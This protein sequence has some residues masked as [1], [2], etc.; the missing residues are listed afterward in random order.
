MGAYCANALL[1]APSPGLRS[2]DLFGPQLY[3]ALDI[4]KAAEE[5][6]GKQA[7]LKL[8]KPE[9]LNDYFA[10]HMPKNCADEMAEMIMA[11][12]PGGVLTQSFAYDESTVRGKISLIDSMREHDRQS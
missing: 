9:G 10:T 12:L 4:K 1:Q 5:I 3:S 7:K 11:L 2:V 8:V 6:T